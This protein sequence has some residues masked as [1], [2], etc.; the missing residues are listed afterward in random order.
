M[1]KSIVQRVGEWMIAAFGED[2]ANDGKERNHRY[3]EESLELVQSLGCTRKEVDMLVDYVYS[4]PLGEPR[5]EVGGASI[6]LA[7][8]CFAHKIDLAQCTEDELARI[9]VKIEQVRAKQLTKPRNSPLPG[10]S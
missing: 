9:W 10:K 7:A 5:Q 2:V 3:L 1:S 4:R 6:T 8:L